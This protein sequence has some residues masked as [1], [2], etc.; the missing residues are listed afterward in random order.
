MNRREARG[1]HGRKQEDE[2]QIN[3]STDRDEIDLHAS[4]DDYSSITLPWPGGNG[5]RL[6]IGYFRLTNRPN[7]K[8]NPKATPMDSYG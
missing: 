8:P 6:W 7:N 2:N 4:R 5:L 3:Y 1:G